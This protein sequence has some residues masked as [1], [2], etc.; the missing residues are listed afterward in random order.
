MSGLPSNPS[1]RK[2]FGEYL[3]TRPDEE[4]HVRS[5][6]EHLHP[7]FFKRLALSAD[8]FDSLVKLQTWAR[9]RWPFWYTRRGGEKSDGSTGKQVMALI[10]ASYLAWAEADES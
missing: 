7:T 5:V 1:R 6:S 4:R 3:A 2:T 9:E 8:H 10:W